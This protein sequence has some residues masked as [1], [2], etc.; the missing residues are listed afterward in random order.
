MFTRVDT[1]LSPACRH[2]LHVL[3]MHLDKDEFLIRPQ[4][5]PSIT[6]LTDLMGCD[7]RTTTRRLEKTERAGWIIRRIPSKSD[8]RKRHARTHYVLVYPAGFF[9]RP[10]DAYPQARGIGA[11]GLGAQFSQPRGANDPGLGAQ[12]PGAR[13]TAPL[14]SSM[15]SESSGSDGIAGMVIRQIRERTGRVITEADAV[16]IAR[17]LL[18]RARGTVRAPE[19]YLTTSLARMNAG[20][21]GALL[22]AQV[23]SA[24]PVPPPFSSLLG[25]DGRFLRKEKEIANDPA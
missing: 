10:E 5:Q 20:E 4:F 7:R 18:G 24:T 1:G 2:V 9:P 22:A 23:A 12:M 16:R 17:E 14:K 25:P 8:Q 13:G 21:L 6:Q 15:S 19:S 3:A 11:S